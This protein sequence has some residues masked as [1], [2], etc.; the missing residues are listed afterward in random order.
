MLWPCSGRRLCI[1]STCVPTATAS[2]SPSFGRVLD[3]NAVKLLENID[4]V[5]NSYVH[6]VRPPNL[7]KVEVKWTLKLGA[8]M[9]LAMK[10]LLVTRRL[11]PCM[12]T[13]PRGQM[14]AL[15]APRC[16]GSMMAGEGLLS[17][18]RTTMQAENEVALVVAFSGHRTC[19]KPSTSSTFSTQAQTACA[20][21]SS[22]SALG[23][24]PPCG[25]ATGTQVAWATSTKAGPLLE[26]DFTC[27]RHGGKR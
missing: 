4:S 1:L 25:L 2:G 14:D 27:K 10:A 21:V 16:A 6:G 17:S 26:M 24:C 15:S 11:V 13:T 5:L 3:R 9:K 23:S 18:S 7:T 22:S 19:A 12:E 8:R 20:K